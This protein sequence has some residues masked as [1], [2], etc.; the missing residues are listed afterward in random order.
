MIRCPIC[1]AKLR[2]NDC[3]HSENCSR[4]GSNLEILIKIEEQA[5]QLN[6]S[7]I[8]HILMGDKER[9]IAQLQQSLALND[10]EF[11]RLLYSF[12]TSY[13]MSNSCYT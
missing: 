12:F 4:C 7:A 13:N 9:A 5:S 11:T 2:V 1:Q 10:T 8:H 6:K 3:N